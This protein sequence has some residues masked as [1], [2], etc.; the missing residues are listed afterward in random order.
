MLTNGEMKV[1][2]PVFPFRASLKALVTDPLIINDKNLTNDNLDKDTWRPI[3]SYHNADK[4]DYVNNLNSWSLMEEG[5]KLYWNGPVPP[6]C[7][8]RI[9]LPIVLFIDKSHHNNNNN[10]KSLLV[11]ILLGV[12]NW[13]AQVHYNNWVHLSFLPNL[14]KCKGTNYNKHDDE[15]I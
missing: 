12:L 7:G 8:L 13:E 10:N 15:W 2:V 6:D 9:S 3:K 11:S 14:H 4:N 5:N 1:T